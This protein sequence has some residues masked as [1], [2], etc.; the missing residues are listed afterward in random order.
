MLATPTIGGN[1]PLISTL[2]AFYLEDAI[3]C[4]NGAWQTNLFEK[5]EKRRETFDLSHVEKEAQSS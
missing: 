2:V 4:G 3:S 5:E 1:N